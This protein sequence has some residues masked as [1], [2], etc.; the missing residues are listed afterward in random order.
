M[1]QKGAPPP[2]GQGRNPGGPQRSESSFPKWAIWALVG[3]VVMVLIVPSLLRR[4]S[5]EKIPY[6]DFITA[7]DVSWNEAWNGTEQRRHF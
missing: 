1:D 7:V 3:L 5:G 2:N 6:S 4:P